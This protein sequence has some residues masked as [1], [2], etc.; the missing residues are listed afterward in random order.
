M[1]RKRVLWLIVPIALVTIAFYLWG[2][3]RTPTGQPP[4]VLLNDSNADEFQQ[5]FNAATAETR[6]VLLLSPT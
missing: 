2:A 4:L 1:T 5:R 6:V 3:S